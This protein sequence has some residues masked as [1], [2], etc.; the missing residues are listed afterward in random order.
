VS[1]CAE[2]VDFNMDAKWKSEIQER[3]LSLYLRLNGYFVSGFIVHSSVPGQNLAE[4]DLLAVRFP[5]NREPERQVDTDSLLEPSS[6]MIDLLICEVKGGAERP[7]FNP[8]LLASADRLCSLLRWA[9][10]HSE[11][12]INELAP[13]VVAALAPNQSPQP[14][15]PMALGPRGTRVRGLICCPDRGAPRD[16]QAWFIPGSAM[17]TYLS[18]CFCPAAPRTACATTYDFGLWHEHESIVRYVKTRGPENVGTM[19]D[20]YSY[21]A[22]RNIR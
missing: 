10:L 4:I 13:K 18:R 7:R 8:S 1:R 2:E 3:L 20:L 17:L 16:N 6:E 15:I 5:H 11:D 14:K 21:F 19:R 12:E 9:G 22:E